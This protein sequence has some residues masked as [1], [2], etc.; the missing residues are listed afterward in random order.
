MGEHDSSD[1]SH[2]EYSNILYSHKYTKEET[3]LLEEHLSKHL[4]LSHL[5][6]LYETN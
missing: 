4:N 1:N 5:S 2:C 6:D 3:D